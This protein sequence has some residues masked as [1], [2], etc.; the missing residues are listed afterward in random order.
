MAIFDLG[1]RWSGLWL[2]L[3]FESPN[4]GEGGGFVFS[5]RGSSV[6][7]A[8][9]RAREANELFSQGEN[10]GCQNVFPSLYIPQSLDYDE[11]LLWARGYSD[12]DTRYCTTP[13]NSKRGGIITS[14]VISSP[15]L[16]NLGNG[17]FT[18]PSFHT[19]SGTCQLRGQTMLFVLSRKTQQDILIALPR[20]LLT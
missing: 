17:Y 20:P 3:V 8:Q 16:L 7:E 12:R 18:F 19:V 15:L 11:M 13:A 4:P 14:H 2:W 6:W 1:L 10:A 5:M 9:L